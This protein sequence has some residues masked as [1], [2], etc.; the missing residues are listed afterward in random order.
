MAASRLTK[1]R[2]GYS[3]NFEP[4]NFRVINLRYQARMVSG[5]TT[6]VCQTLDGRSRR[7]LKCS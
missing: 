2:P 5:L 6:Q 3:R 1:G 7:F 4:S